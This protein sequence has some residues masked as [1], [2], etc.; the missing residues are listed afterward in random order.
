MDPD[1]NFVLMLFQLMFFAV[2]LYIPYLIITKIVR[3]IIGT[4]KKT[5]NSFRK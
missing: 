1:Y 5:V 3:G 2:L 4:S